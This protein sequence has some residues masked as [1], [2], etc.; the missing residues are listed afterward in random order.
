MDNISKRSELY[1]NA[2]ENIR[3]IYAGEKTGEL[4]RSAADSIGI[5]DRV[6]Y[7][8]FAL[9][10]GDVILGLYRK[11]QLGQLLQER[12]SFTTEQVDK[13]LI[14]LNDLIRSVPNNE[15]AELPTPTVLAPSTPSVVVQ[16]P[17]TKPLRTFAED[18]SLSRAHGYGAFRSP[19]NTE[20]AGAETI[21][22]SNQDDI[23]KQ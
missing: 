4:L 12:L 13:V 6:I 22:R 7:K 11:E 16:T 17:I 3:D 15:N 14:T 18:A 20:G 8:D 1:K 10:V 23:I 9:T 19:E 21:H 5:T 2:P